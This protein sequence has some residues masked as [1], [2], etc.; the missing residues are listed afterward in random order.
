MSHRKQ[1]TIITISHYQMQP[2]SPAVQGISVTFNDSLPMPGRDP[3][4][5]LNTERRPQAPSLW[6]K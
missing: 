5:L 3:K 4:V 6:V 1:C 2:L